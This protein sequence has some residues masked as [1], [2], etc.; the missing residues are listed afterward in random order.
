MRSIPLASS[1]Q[2]SSVEN[3]IL[4]SSNPISKSTHN[5]NLE[6]LG[7]IKK[8]MNSSV[9]FSSM[10]KNGLK[11]LSTLREEIRTPSKI[12][13]FSCSKIKRKVASPTPT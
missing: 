4:V 10:A 8:I 11:W 9:S 1:V 7:L 2:A 6:D 12:D 3:I 13:S 5:F